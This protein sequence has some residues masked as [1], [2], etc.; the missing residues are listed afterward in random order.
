[1]SYLALMATFGACVLSGLALK[2][3]RRSRLDA[4]NAYM[5]AKAIGSKLL[6]AIEQGNVNLDYFTTWM[7]QTTDRLETLEVLMPADAQGAVRSLV[8][9]LGS[10]ERELVRLK[11]GLDFVRDQFD[12]IVAFIPADPCR[13]DEPVAPFLDND[14][15]GVCYT[16]P[17][18]PDDL[19]TAHPTPAEAAGDVFDDSGEFTAGGIHLPS[20]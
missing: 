14:G 5:T 4:D 17:V 1:M 19:A 13:D 20:E 2:A 6:K 10:L 7:A 18:Q 11:Q 16:P 3:A 12:D 8:N 9:R 15:Y